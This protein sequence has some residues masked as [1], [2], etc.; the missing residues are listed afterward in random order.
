MGA[1]LKHTCVMPVHLEQIQDSSPI[2]GSAPPNV[3]AKKHF[4]V[5]LGNIA[6]Q[7][8]A[9]APGGGWAGKKGCW[10]AKLVN[11][12]PGGRGGGGLER[13]R[14]EFADKKGPIWPKWLWPGEAGRLGWHTPPPRGW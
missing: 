1:F 5:K 3:K 11:P 4:Q 2:P 10:L 9:Q 13:W 6:S 8:F 14:L 12:T 7:S